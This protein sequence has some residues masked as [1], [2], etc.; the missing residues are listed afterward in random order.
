MNEP[1]RRR[2]LEKTKHRQSENKTLSYSEFLHLSYSVISK[3]LQSATSLQV[4]GTYVSHFS[5]N[6]GFNYPVALA[7]SYLGSFL[8]SYVNGVFASFRIPASRLIL[9]VVRIQHAHY[10]FSS[11][12]VSVKLH[13]AF[14]LT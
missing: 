7:T 9:V 14:V 4:H 6:N 10:H 12:M 1:C 11:S 2:S 5:F 13:T 8:W 3:K